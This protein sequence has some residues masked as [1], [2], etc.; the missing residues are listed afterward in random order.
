MK[1]EFLN[2]ILLFITLVFFAF[3]VSAQKPGRFDGEN[4]IIISG[5]SNVQ[6]FVVRY[7]FKKRLEITSSADTGCSS[8]QN[9]LIQIPVNKLLFS[10]RHMRDD[11]L[12]LVRANQFP[13]I[14]LYYDPKT[15]NRFEDHSK[16]TVLITIQITNVKQTYEVPVSLL[17]DTKT[18]TKLKG[19]IELKL[20]DFKLTPKRY[21]FGLIRIKDMLNINFILYFYR[22]VT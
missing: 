17:R 19:K 16:K 7:Y 5:E 18:Y 21:F 10:N 8:Q 11:F 22:K 14:K 13:L 20:S 2:R 3:Q 4:K 6:D 1:K 15:L 9:G 12:N